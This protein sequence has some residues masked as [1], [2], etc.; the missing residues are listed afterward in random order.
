MTVGIR[1]RLTIGMAALLLLLAAASSVA[2]YAL[3]TAQ[4]R[5]ETIVKLDWRKAHL[6][7][8]MAARANIV[9]RTLTE[10]QYADAA[11]IAAGK[12]TIKKAREEALFAMNEIDKMLYVEEGRKLFG[13]FK[14]KRQAYAAVYP[15]I[16]TLLE[17]GQREEALA[18]QLKEGLPAVRGYIQ[19][20]ENF[21]ALQGRL[22]E[23][24]ADAAAAAST[25][26]QRA[27]IGF[28][29]VALVLSIAIAAWVVRGVLRPLGGEPETA[30]AIVERIADGDLTTDVPIAPNDNSSLLASMSK[31]QTKLRAMI[32]SLKADADRLLDASQSVTTASSQVASSAGYQSET[33]ASMAASIEQLTSSFGLVSDNMR[34]THEVTGKTESVSSSGAEIIQKTADEMRRIA[35][36]AQ[37]SSQTIVDMGESSEKISKI[38]GIIR[39]IAEQTNLLALNAAI[40][41]ARAGEQGRGFAVVADEVRKLAERT[42]MATQE[43]AT[44]VGTVQTGVGQAVAAMEEM[45]SCVEQ[46]VAMAHQAS[47]SI[48]DIRQG[49]QNV[50]ASVDQISEAIQEQGTASQNIAHHIER[51]ASMSEENSAAATEAASTAELLHSL[52]GNVHHMLSGFR[53]AAT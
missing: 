8:H 51:L 18:L 33:A 40:E 6:A 35:T 42:S 47:S 4:S 46:G 21:V 13:A 27:L 9:A 53:V 3:H 39:S 41:A 25:F 16:V 17:A 45:T 15:Q 32:E 23:Q 10:M 1:T 49:T 30:R 7:N 52:A 48:E 29:C 14:E 24:N 26:A 38:V 43:I 11:G 36:V 37:Q 2:I 12:E 28:L 22:F 19:G 20:A 44:V 31:M 50:Y 34:K 5:M